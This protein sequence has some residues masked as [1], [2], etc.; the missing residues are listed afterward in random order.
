MIVIYKNFIKRGP[1]I[2]ISFNKFLF[3]DYLKNNLK[4]IKCMLL[5]HDILCNPLAPNIFNFLKVKN[6][7]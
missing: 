4:F 7:M 3:G 6:L 2:Q 5:D 1:I